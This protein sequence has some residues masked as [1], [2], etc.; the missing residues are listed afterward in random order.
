MYYLHKY[1]ISQC[2]CCN[3]HGACG[4]HAAGPSIVMAHQH[5]NSGNLSVSLYLQENNKQV[6]AFTTKCIFYSLLHFPRSTRKWCASIETHESW[7][8][9]SIGLDDHVGYWFSLT[10]A[11]LSVF[12]LSATARWTVTRASNVFLDCP[13]SPISCSL[14]ESSRIS[15]TWYL[16]SHATIS[17]STMTVLTFACQNSDL[18]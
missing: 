10:V 1:P 2:Q 8:H 12:T 4:A 5:Q 3:T 7:L 15:R 18:L 16:H 17:A 6:C 14:L 9:W 13:L 11:F